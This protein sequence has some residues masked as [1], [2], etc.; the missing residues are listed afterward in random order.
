MRLAVPLL[1]ALVLAACGGGPGDEQ[2]VQGGAA[3][4]SMSAD[5]RAIRATLERYE[6]AVRANDP[7]AVCALTA[8]EVLDT[9]EEVGAECESMIAAQVK[10]GG[11][12]FELRTNSVQVDGD[13]AMTRGQAVESDGPRSG[14]QPLV[15]EGDRWLLTT[16]AR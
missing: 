5:E 8:R 4:P 15:R 6:Q 1:L 10:E 11:P 13:Y 12:Q 7:A 14:D 2:P 9:I 3:Q 16:K